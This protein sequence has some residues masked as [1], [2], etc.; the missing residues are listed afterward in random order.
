[1]WN[2]IVVFAVGV[3]VVSV[4]MMV[5]SMVDDIAYAVR[6]RVRMS[7]RSMSIRV[8]ATTRIVVRMERR[9]DPALTRVVN[10]LRRERA[11]YDR[12]MRTGEYVNATTTNP[13][14]VDDMHMSMSRY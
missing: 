4:C 12:Y 14:P 13:D 3:G 9:P 1:M 2:A 10:Q 8:N 5:A 7:R 11:I 6:R